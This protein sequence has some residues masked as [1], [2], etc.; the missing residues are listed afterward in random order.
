M[1]QKKI[2]SIF[3]AWNET[4]IWSCLQGVMGEIYANTNEDGAMA[5]LG[6]F[7]FLPESHVKN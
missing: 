3:E 4:L 2:E 1:E 5:L 7:A 6:D